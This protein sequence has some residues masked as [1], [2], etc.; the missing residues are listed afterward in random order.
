MV[1]KDDDKEMK[2]LIRMGKRHNDIKDQKGIE[3]IVF[4]AT[5]DMENFGWQDEY[6]G[7]KD[8][9]D[10]KEYIEARGGFLR[11]AVSSKTDYLI[12][13]DLTINTTKIR[14][15]KELGVLIISERDF[16]NMSK[17]NIEEI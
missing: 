2:R 10:L 1:L 3:G 13:N 12:C 11:S 9:S 7:A 5:G 16:L 15:A 6:T 14:K 8:W 17:N 4:V